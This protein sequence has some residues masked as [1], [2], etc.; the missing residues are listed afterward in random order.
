MQPDRAIYV[1]DAVL[2]LVFSAESERMLCQMIRK[3]LLFFSLPPKHKRWSANT[4]VPLV[5]DDTR[6]NCDVL[7]LY[8]TLSNDTKV[9]VRQVC[10]RACVSAGGLF[11][12]QNN[13]QKTPKREVGGS[14][15]GGA[16][17]SCGAQAASTQA[18]DPVCTKTY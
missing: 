12:E 4:S 1:S 11:P 18:N 3:N 10:G 2:L 5:E 6:L 9:Y 8:G 7:G 14:M 15:G 17:S 13:L 16:L